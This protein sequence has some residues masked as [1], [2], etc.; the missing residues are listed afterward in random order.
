MFWSRENLLGSRE[1]TGLPTKDVTLTT[2]VELLSTL[3]F[4]NYVYCNSYPTVLMLAILF[5][6]V[7]KRH[8]KSEDRNIFKFS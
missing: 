4:I 7:Y 5:I 6:N 3:I 2:T 8:T 1:N